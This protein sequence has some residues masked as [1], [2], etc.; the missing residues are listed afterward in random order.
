MY[1]FKIPCPTCGVTRA[2]ISLLRLDLKSYFY[3]HP[4]S[5]PLIA[6]VLMMIHIKLFK[7]K[8]LIYVFSGIILLANLCLYVVRLILFF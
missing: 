2:V 4:L 7:N 6:V 1:F 8:L 3:F 5:V